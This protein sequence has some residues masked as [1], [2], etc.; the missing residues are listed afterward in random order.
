[1]NWFTLLFIFLRLLMDSKHLATSFIAKDVLCFSHTNEHSSWIRLSVPHHLPVAAVLQRSVWLWGWWTG[2]TAA[3]GSPPRPL[4]STY[5]AAPEPAWPPG[6]GPSSH[7]WGTLSGPTARGGEG[8]RE[9]I[10]QQV[11][12]C[13][14]CQNPRGTHGYLLLCSE[15]VSELP[16]QVLLFRG[17]LFGWRVAHNYLLVLKMNKNQ[18]DFSYTIGSNWSVFLN[19]QESSQ[20]ILSVIWKASSC[21]LNC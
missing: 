12:F 1:M 7:T 17:Q 8:R 11:Q 13:I 14:C 20:K 15:V 19:F 3:P 6:E 16:H 18:L 10:I 4:A 9:G 5:Q 2:R 21:L